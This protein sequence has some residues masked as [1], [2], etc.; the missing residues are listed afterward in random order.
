MVLPPA[1]ARAIPHNYNRSGLFGSTPLDS[2]RF[3]KVCLVRELLLER[4]VLMEVEAGLGPHS[5]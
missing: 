5:E 3:G 2:G 1:R 4:S